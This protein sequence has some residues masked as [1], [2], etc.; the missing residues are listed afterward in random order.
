MRGMAGAEAGLISGLGHLVAFTGTETVPVLQF[1]EDYYP[2]EG[3]LAGTVPATEHSV[4]CA[5]GD[6]NERETFQRLL[7]LYPEG[8]L[9]VVSD[10]WDFWRVL[11]EHLPALKDQIMAR[12]GK[13]VIRPDSGDPADIVCGVNSRLADDKLGSYTIEQQKGAYELLWD[14]FGGTINEK[15]YKVLDPHVGVIYGDAM[16]YDRIQDICARLEAKGFSI[17]SMVF[18]LGSYGYQYQ[19]RDTFGF[20]M[21][22]TNVTIDGEDRA[23]FKDP[24]TD[25]GLKKSLK[26]RIAVM[27]VGGELVAFDD[28][29]P[30]ERAVAEMTGGM[31]NLLKTVWKDGKFVKTYSF[32]EVRKNAGFVA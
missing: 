1:V 4:M 18:G 8:I 16:N 22:A 14:L 17:E 7:D 24:V 3:F 9:S 15:G 27:E 11:T 2:M 10:T 12:N 19:T 25:S 30:D 26:G 13:L 21:K 32:D 28:S 6:E 29:M 20:A 23:I 5:G 31:D